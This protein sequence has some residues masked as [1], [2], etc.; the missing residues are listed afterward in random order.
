M[1]ELA[2]ILVLGIFAQWLAW[3]VK[4]PA[5][6]PLLFLGLLL[7]PISTL[8]TPT[9]EKLVDGD[10]IFQEEMLF[11]FVAIS[12]GVILF[13][14]GLTLKIQEIRKQASVVRNILTIGVLVT[15]IGGTLASHYLMDLTW[16]FSFLFGALIIVSGPTVVTPILRN[17]KPNQTT[18]TILKWEGILID[19]LGALI[20]VLAFG[21]VRTSKSEQ[22]YTL[23]ALKDFFLTMANGAFL[24]VVAAFILFYLLKKNRLPT[25]LKNVVTLALVILVF[26]LSELIMKE[27]G[28]LAV[29]VMGIILA[30]L[31]IEDIKLIL[32]FKEDISMILISVLFLLL[33]SRMELQ[34]LSQLGTN[35][36]I[37]FFVVI[38]L[39]RPIGV[40]LSTIKSELKLR[41]KIFIS[42][43][44]P[45]GIVAAAVASLFSLELSMDETNMSPIE[46]A[47]ARLILPLV[48]MFILGTVVVQGS[49]A[50]LMAKWL[51]VER[52]ESPG[53]LFVGANEAARYIAKYL[54]DNGVPV[55]LAD[56]AHTNLID[57]AQ[58]GMETYGGNI[59]KENLWEEI[60]LSEMGQ[61]LAF[62]SNTEINVLACR[63]FRDEFGEENNLRLI[64]RREIESNIGKSKNLLFNGTIDF[65]NLIQLVRE[66]PEIIETPISSMAE[67]EDFV[68]DR[69][70]K[71]IPMFIK[72]SSNKFKAISGFP[73]EFTKGDQLVYMEDEYFAIK[74]ENFQ[75]A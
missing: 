42:W 13:E 28:L 52:K 11:S 64:S 60:D 31:D 65:I 69:K 75:D 70:T 34:E 55:L 33:S 38:L 16:R 67:Y 35:S 48:F 27:S 61:L 36:V 56:T 51:R 50:K 44:G 46:A 14:G 1:L 19:P 7:G 39:V 9:G 62:T 66:S 29:T 54:H 41:E 68:N 2:A 57:T 24:G 8:F 4:V 47:D 15:L 59:L 23:I 71:I 58:M 6:L 72:S 5:I 22:E 73:Q 26:A 12:V 63:K 17:V 74:T 21:F 25:Y 20:A 10:S 37:L 30:N 53:I 32:T 3:K 45:K 43:I 40:F 49:S 18:N